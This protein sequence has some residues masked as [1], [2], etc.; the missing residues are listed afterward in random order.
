MP[1]PLPPSSKEPFV[2]SGERADVLLLHGYTGTPYEVRPVADELASRGFSCRA[3]LLPGH[4]TIASELNRVKAEGW[5]AAA[6]RAFDLLDRSRPRLVVGASMG[7]LLAL[8]IAAD[9]P[10]EVTGVALLA[11]ALRFF[12]SAQLA[13]G[14][15]EV[16]AVR[17]VD[18][19]RKVQTGGDLGDEEARGKNPCYTTLPVAGMGELSRLARWARRSLPDVRVPVCVVHGARD[20][21]I[22]PRASAEV[23]RGVRSDWVERYVLPRSRHVIGLD[24]ERDRVCNIVADFACELVPAADA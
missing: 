11:P 4:G 2:L 15:A 12:P 14:F 23:A 22:P 18:Q 24:V 1:R 21:T 7:G 5:L 16:G 6:H 8:L 10:G 3:P 20:R 17:V 13:L 9:R 19:V